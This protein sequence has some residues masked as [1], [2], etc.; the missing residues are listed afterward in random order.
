MMRMLRYVD[1]GPEYKVSV[2]H[3]L[4]ILLTVTLADG[5]ADTS[6]LVLTA[7]VSFIVGIAI[8]FG[9]V[10]YS[11]M[12]RPAIKSKRSHHQSSNIY[13]STPLQIM[14]QSTPLR[15]S[16]DLDI[17][18]KTYAHNEFADFDELPTRCALEVI[19]SDTN[20][21]RVNFYN[22]DYR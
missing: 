22:R 13:T 20:S 16:I 8:T 9:V 15:S 6:K 10:C 1:V 17:D 18:G 11:M 5:A 14:Q 7:I 4:T 19:R 3:F 12:H 21:A 2:Y